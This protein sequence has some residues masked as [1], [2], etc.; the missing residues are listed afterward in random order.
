MPDISKFQAL[1]NTVYNIKDLKGRQQ[2]SPIENSSVSTS[3]YVIGQYLQLDGILY[4]TIA[5]IQIGDALVVD[6]NI[7]QVKISEEL[8]KT[9]QMIT[10][11]GLSVVDGKLCVT[12]EVNT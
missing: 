3:S 7:E 1:D 9:I 12:Y 4:I 8:L 6:T 11:L 10:D 2:I 5:P